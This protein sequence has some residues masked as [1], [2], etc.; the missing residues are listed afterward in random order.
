YP[1]VIAQYVRDD[2][3]VGNEEHLHWAL[4]VVKNTDKL[5]GDIFQA[6]DRLYYGSSIASWERS[7]RSDA[8]LMKTTKC[9]GL[10]QIGSVKARDLDSFIAV[11]GDSD[12]SNGHPAIPKFPGWRCKDWILEVID[13]LKLQKS[14]WI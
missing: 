6:V 11:V 12:Q 8:D 10:I 5:K 4:M 2:Y 13:L 9:V 7:Y 3:G 14:G 1:V